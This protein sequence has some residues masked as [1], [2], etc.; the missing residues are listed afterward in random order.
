MGRTGNYWLIAS[1]IHSFL[2]RWESILSNHVVITSYSIHYTKL[3]EDNRIDHSSDFLAAPHT[4]LSE[5]EYFEID[6]ADLSRYGSINELVQEKLSNTSLPDYVIVEFPSIIPNQ[7]PTELVSCIDLHVLVC[8]ANRIWTDADRTATEMLAKFTGQPSVFVLNG[9]ELQA[10]EAIFGEL[11]KKRSKFRKAI[12]K[13]VQL[14]FL[15][16]NQI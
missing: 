7:Y 12:K 2:C 13:L 10:I 11:P 9:V 15:S 6:T 8:R 3:Y 14:Q 4:Y 16:Q 5:N 1:S